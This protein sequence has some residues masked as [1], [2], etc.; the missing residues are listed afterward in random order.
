VFL[1][2]SRV[3]EQRGDED[4][5]RPFVRYI[6]RVVDLATLRFTLA[7][8]R[9]KLGEPM[10]GKFRSAAEELE[11]RGLERGEQQGRLYTLLKQLE[12]RFGPLDVETRRRVEHA[13]PE[14]LDGMIERVLSATTVAEVVGNS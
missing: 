6:V 3:V 13:S 9:E 11:Q 10:E 5:L 1:L 14:A 8:V 4:A 12:L 2:M 7:R